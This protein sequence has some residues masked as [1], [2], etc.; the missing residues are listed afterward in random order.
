M[1]STADSSISEH[2]RPERAVYHMKTCH[3]IHKYHV[4]LIEHSAE[5]PLT[6]IDAVLSFSFAVELFASIW[7]KKETKLM[8][9]ACRL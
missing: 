7:S 2:C 1:L 6:A 4:Q 9:V 8:I 3:T 5:L